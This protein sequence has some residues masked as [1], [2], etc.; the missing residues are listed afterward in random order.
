MEKGN[1]N[2]LAAKRSAR[3]REG[4]TAERERDH[5][6]GTRVNGE[7]ERAEAVGKEEGKENKKSK[8]KRRSR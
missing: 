6:K 8:R 3:W 7:E 2:P 1:N 5:R 4:G